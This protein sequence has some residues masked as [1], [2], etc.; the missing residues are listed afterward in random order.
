MRRSV[1]GTIVLAL[2]TACTSSPEIAAPD[3]YETEEEDTFRLAYPPGW[4]PV[5]EAE[6][7]QALEETPEGAPPM[8]INV[9][10]DD[11]QLPSAEDRVTMLLTDY[12]IDFGDGLEL[13]SNEATTVPGAQSARRTEV[14]APTNLEATGEE[15]RLRQI[16]VVAQREDGSFVVLQVY[17]PADSF[18]RD[19]AENIV[20][21]FAVV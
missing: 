9:F 18:D 20:S 7:F 10:V 13:V 19:A 14:L 6:V 4:D 5:A 3:G 16:D 2:L 1:A 8:G 21:S 11:Q 17:G 12:R 15:V